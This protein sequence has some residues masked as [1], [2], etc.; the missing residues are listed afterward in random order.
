MDIISTDVPT[1]PAELTVRRNEFHKVSLITRL[2]LKSRRSTPTDG[3]IDPPPLLNPHLAAW[4]GEEA[5][6]DSSGIKACRT[7]GRDR[8]RLKNIGTLLSA[9]KDIAGSPI[10]DNLS[11]H[12]PSS[13]ILRNDVPTSPPAKLTS[14]NIYFV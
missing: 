5:E 9:V 12:V 6:R 4:R 7:F 8:V 3:D 13:G 1:T 14:T 10:P 2:E 11:L